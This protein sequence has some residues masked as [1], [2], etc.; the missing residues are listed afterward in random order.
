MTLVFVTGI[1]GAGKSAVLPE[2]RRRGYLAYSTDEDRLCRWF[3]NDT[4]VE[5]MLPAEPLGLI[6]EHSEAYIQ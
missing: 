6:T 2:L 5:L 1:S 4:G 3:E